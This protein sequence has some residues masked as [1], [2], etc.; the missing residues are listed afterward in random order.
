MIIGQII[1]TNDAEKNYLQ[2]KDL[3]DRLSKKNKKF[4]FINCYNLIKKKK[5]L[6]MN[7]VLI[8]K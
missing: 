8:K 5:F 4:Y 3:I 2:Q 6:I 1:A 7:F